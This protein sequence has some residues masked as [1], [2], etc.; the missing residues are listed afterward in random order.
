MSVGAV[1]ALLNRHAQPTAA[2]ARWPIS[3]VQDVVAVLAVYIGQ[4]GIPSTQF[5]P[6]MEAS[7]SPP[8]PPESVFSDNPLLPKD[9]LSPVDCKLIAVYGDTIHDNDGSH[10][11]GGIS[12]DG[13]WQKYWATLTAL[14]CQRYDVPS[15]EVSCRF[16]FHL[17][18]LLQGVVDWKWNSKH[19][20]VFL[21]VVLQR[22]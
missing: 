6:P 20:F 19:F 17:A 9:L 18:V 16:I 11:H 2:P 7:S 1:V 8:A 22:K 5:G 21:A 10:M 13:D 15:G 14:P 3:C 4:V 12:D